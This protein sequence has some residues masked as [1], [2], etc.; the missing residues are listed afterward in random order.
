MEGSNSARRDERGLPGDGT[1]SRSTKA[2]MK[3][4]DTSN[5]DAS[6]NITTNWSVG[7][8]NVIKE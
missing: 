4:T 5:T 7:T 2:E 1:L 8:T 3:G 6:S